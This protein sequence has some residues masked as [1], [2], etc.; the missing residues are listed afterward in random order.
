MR[1]S[2]FI[3]VRHCPSFQNVYR[4]LFFPLLELCGGSFSLQKNTDFCRSLHHF[5]PCCFL[6]LSTHFVVSYLVNTGNLSW[7]F[8]HYFPM[9]IP[10]W[11]FLPCFYFF[12]CHL[13]LIVRFL[14]TIYLL[15]F[16]WVQ[17]FRS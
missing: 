15:G 8:Y 17:S 6:C 13:Q 2:I 4:V 3:T 12:L 1:L 7:C 5:H 9:L 16:R 11:V 14:C 10:L